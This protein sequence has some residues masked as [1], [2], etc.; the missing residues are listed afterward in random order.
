M[1]AGKSGAYSLF[2]AAAVTTQWLHLTNACHSGCC[3]FI[4][5]PW[6]SLGSLFTPRSSRRPKM[7][8]FRRRHQDR[9]RELDSSDEKGQAHQRGPYGSTS[10]DP[11]STNTSSKH[12][13]SVSPHEL[14][15]S[16]LEDDFNPEHGA[17]T[18]NLTMATYLSMGPTWAERCLRRSNTM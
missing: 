1:V 2:M 7:R 13:G 6:S 4:A 11:R 18:D 10:S 8:L 15:E 17:S 3:D 9:D 16:P 12:D 5:R 14:C